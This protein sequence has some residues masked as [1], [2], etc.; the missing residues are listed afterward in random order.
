MFFVYLDWVLIANF[1]I[2]FEYDQTDIYWKI[3]IYV[4]VATSRENW[5][6]W[7]WS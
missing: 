6:I 5:E 3:N 2:L 1:R 7:N 4:W